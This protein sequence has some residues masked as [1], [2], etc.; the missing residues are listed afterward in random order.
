MAERIMRLPKDAPELDA[1]T[2]RLLWVNDW[3]D[4]PSEAVVEVAG[5]RCLLRLESIDA[6]EGDRAA[7][8]IVYRL[9]PHERAELERVHE[10]Y[11]TLVGSHWCFHEETHAD[12]APPQ[13]ETFYAAH[14]G[15]SPVD[16]TALT[17][18][19]W[20]ASLPTR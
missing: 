2:V 7:R 17:P 19:G 11:A 8:W 20:L 3:Y 12:T 15:R 9:S 4:A 14:R 16:L 1:G 5:T 18:I 13:P 6:L 10:L